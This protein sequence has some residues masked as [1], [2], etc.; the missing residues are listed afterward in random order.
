MTGSEHRDAHDSTAPPALADLASHS[1]LVQ[2]LQRRYADLLV[3][4][5]A[6]AP[7]RESLSTALAALRDKGLALDA[8]LRVL[9]QLTLERLVHLDT[10]QQGQQV[11]I[12]ALQTL[13][14]T[15]M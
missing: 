5:P 2:R 14:K 13:H 1:R 4:L 8:A 9:R 12:P 10:G 7:T 6:G 3:L 11:G 15:G